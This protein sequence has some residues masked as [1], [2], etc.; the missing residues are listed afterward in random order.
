MISAHRCGAGA[1]LALGNGRAAL[2]RALQLDVDFV[3]FDVQ[4]CG[5]DT[6]V[7]H[8]DDHIV[9]DGER[10]LLTSLTFDEFAS[11][12]DDPI[13]FKQALEIL[14]RSDKKAHIDF[15]FSTGDGETEDPE[16]RTEV[17]AARLAIDTLGCENFII[18][19]LEDD[20]VRALRD[21]SDHQDIALMVGLSL[22]RDLVGYS[23]IDKVV[24]RMSELFPSRR[25]RE[26]R[27]NLVVV[28]HRLAYFGVAEWAARRSLPL[29][30]WTVDGQARLSR[31]LFDERVWLV[32]TNF[33]QD[34][35]R[36]IESG[37]GSRRS[38]TSRRRFRSASS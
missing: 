7:L 35:R 23:P 1:D 18:T 6:F 32:T 13:T 4:L 24:I 17:A 8:H 5:D 19:T 10:I 34:A 12:V 15:K 22:G 3:E 30:V 28:H 36:I 9:A 2:E 29:L 37:V 33:P 11:L 21:W 26:S 25:F 31:W 16:A 27:A 20:S 38:S 14:Q